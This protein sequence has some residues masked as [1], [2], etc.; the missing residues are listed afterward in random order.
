VQ[1][2]IWVKAQRA[3]NVVIVCHLARAGYNVQRA[4]R[5]LGVRAYLVHDRHARSMR[6]S[7]GCRLLHKCD[8]LSTADAEA[9]A[10]K[11]NALHRRVGILSVISTDVPATMLV[12]RMQSM[13]RPAIFPFPAAD[14]LQALDN[15][16]EFAKICAERQVPIPKT[17]HF[18]NS[19][20]FDPQLVETELSYP[21]IVKP[22][23]GFGQ[24]NIVVIAG[25][26]EA[27]I[28]RRLETHP[29]AIVVQ[30]FVAGRDWALSTFSRNGIV[31]HW[32][33]WECPG[34]LESQDSTSRY[35]VARF[36]TTNFRRHDALVEMG[37]QVI[38]ATGYSGVANFDA[39]LAENGRMVLLECNPRFFNRMLAARM[40][41]LDFLA[42]GL[43]GSEEDRCSLDD[44]DYYPWQEI[45][46][47]RGLKRLRSGEW[48]VRHL[49]TDLF[50]MACDPL[51]PLI[52]NIT[53]EDRK[54]K[55]ISR[56]APTRVAEA[57]LSV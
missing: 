42:A 36:Q 17:L 25:P 48:H 15:K 32:C 21:V 34:Q 40:C 27:E 55:Q 53:G 26:A 3:P 51:P 54:A 41:G 46:T 14:V 18:R 57:V 52:R 10:G 39:R 37:R 13:L 4:L 38:A 49:V 12:A 45:F 2:L 35:G 43:Y 24:H 28:Y 33:T 23:V 11:I 19:A 9:I 16:W 5:A 8:E 6:W 50:E 7:H 30:E 22:A 29:L 56:V 31:T 47:W 1:R 20:A 44:A